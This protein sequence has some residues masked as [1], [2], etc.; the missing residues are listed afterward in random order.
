MNFYD[1]MLEYGWEFYHGRRKISWLRVPQ[2]AIYRGI[3]CQVSF[4]LLYPR[5][6]LFAGLLLSSIMIP[7]YVNGDYL[8]RPLRPIHW[9]MQ[10][11]F[12]WAMGAMFVRF[13]VYM[14]QHW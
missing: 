7:Y 6:F 8:E 13:E 1:T 12:S 5:S 3:L 4:Y 9:F 10:T 2:E 11:M 14:E